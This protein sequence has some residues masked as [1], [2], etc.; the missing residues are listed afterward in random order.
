METCRSCRA[1][2][3]PEWDRCKICGAERGASTSES[4]ELPYA[5]E[6]PAPVA[7]SS[8]TSPTVLVACVVGGLL[9]VGALLFLVTRGGGDDESDTVQMPTVATEPD[10]DGVTDVAVDSKDP[11]EE[12]KAFCAGTAPYPEAGPYPGPAGPPHVIDSSGFSGSMPVEW[13]AGQ[14]QTAGRPVELVLCVTAIPTGIRTPCD[15]YNT[16]IPVFIEDTNYDVQLKA[17]ASGEVLASTSWP[18]VSDCPSHITFAADKSEVVRPRQPDS[19]LP[20]EFVRPFVA[21]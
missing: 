15:G 11:L 5:V 16:N 9:V 21:P 3:Q 19:A 6:E 8:G 14:P 7:R 13:M 2:L 17:A 1:F 4:D 10:P 12:V 20:V 18:G